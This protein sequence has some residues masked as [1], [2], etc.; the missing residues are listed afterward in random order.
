MSSGAKKTLIKVNQ[1]ENIVWARKKYINEDNNTFT[2]FQ[3]LIET[4]CGKHISS[5]RVTF[6]GSSVEKNGNYIL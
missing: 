5:T 1:L 4:Q 2:N 3:D 6:D